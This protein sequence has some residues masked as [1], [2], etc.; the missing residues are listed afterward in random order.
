MI[1]ALCLACATGSPRTARAEDDA[2]AAAI[3][4]YNRAREH[5]QAGQ[6]RQAVAELERALKLDPSSPNLVYNVARVYE[7]LGEIERAIE[8]YSSYE[9]MLPKRE[10]EERERVQAVLQRLRG[11][12]QEVERPLDDPTDPQ[13]PVRRPDEPALERGVADTAFWSTAGLGAAALI[14]GGVV[15]WLAMQEEQE[16]LDF[17]LTSPDE[18]EAR[19]SRARSADRAGAAIRSMAT[20]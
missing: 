15:G 17:R 12:R 16:A 2:P 4:H 19:D 14:G 18:V 7:L 5:Y 9:K 8:Y 10:R 11:A 20:R 1:V 6:Y 3:A 13:K